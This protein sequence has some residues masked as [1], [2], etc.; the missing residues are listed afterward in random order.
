MQEKKMKLTII[1]D[2]E[3]LTGFK[4]GW[5]FSC[6]IENAGKKVLFDTGCNRDQFMFNLNKLGIK[7]NDIDIIVL[8][9]EHHDHTTGLTYVIHP[10]ADVYVPTSFSK[11]LKKDIDDNAKLHQVRKGETIAEG[12]HTTGELG[13]G[14]KEQSLV[15]ETGKGLIVLTGCAH[16][17]LENILDAANSFGK[18][19]GVAGGFHGF[20]ELDQLEGLSL[21]IPCHCTKQKNAIMERFP[22]RVEKCGSGKIFEL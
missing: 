19:I 11:D 17:G 21:I 13:G 20:T 3:A 22:K 4:S 12:I 6:L 9:H 18:I 15:L 5:G 1:Y 7:K 8:S 2:N 10:E 16:P 14:I